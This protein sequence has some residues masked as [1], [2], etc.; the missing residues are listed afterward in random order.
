MS[1]YMFSKYTVVVLSIKPTKSYY[2]QANKNR[3]SFHSPILPFEFRHLNSVPICMVVLSNWASSKLQ[4]LRL[5][6]RNPPHVCFRTRVFYTVIFCPH[7]RS[8]QHAKG[9]FY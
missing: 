9:H 1:P 5:E 6:L 7:V 2:L 4:I 3:Y 8:S